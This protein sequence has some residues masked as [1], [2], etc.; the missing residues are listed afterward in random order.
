[1]ALSEKYPRFSEWPS[2]FTLN[3]Q[4][5]TFWVEGSHSPMSAIVRE[6]GMQTFSAH[7]PKGF[8]Y[9]AELL[10]KAF[11]D[12]YRAEHLGKA[13]EGI[14]FDGHSY[15]RQIADDSWQAFAKQDIMLHLKTQ[16]KISTSGRKAE[17]SEMED[18]LNYI[19]SHAFIKAAGPCVFQ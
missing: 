1:P 3:S 6:T 5:P 7:A 13:V 11:V 10:G 16:R 18:C 15:W 19:Q 14:Y 17:A 4:G 2:E 12:K 8:Y 9:W